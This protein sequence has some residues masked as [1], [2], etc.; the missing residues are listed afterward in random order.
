MERTKDEYKYFIVKISF[1]NSQLTG[2]LVF[3]ANSFGE[4]TVSVIRSLPNFLKLPL[5]RGGQP[6]LVRGARTSSTST[7]RRQRGHLRYIEM[8]NESNSY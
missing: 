5:V 7:A 2:K 3:L 1:K 6:K 4:R 8:S